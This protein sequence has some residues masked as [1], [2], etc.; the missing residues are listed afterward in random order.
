M[1]VNRTVVQIVTL[2]LERVDHAGEW[3]RLGHSVSWS[4]RNVLEVVLDVFSI[5]RSLVDL[6]DFS[7]GVNEKRGRKA[8][9]TMAVK[10]IAIEKVVNAGQIVRSLQDGK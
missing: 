2:E 3:Q 4:L 8:Q 10:K 7:A 6:D 5:Q 1:K 9:V